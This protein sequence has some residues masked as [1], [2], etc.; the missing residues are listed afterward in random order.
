[1]S[2]LSYRLLDQQ[3]N[4]V[5]FNAGGS[6]STIEVPPEAH[7]VKSISLGKQ[8]VSLNY[9]LNR[10]GKY[11]VG[12]AYLSTGEDG[13]PP[14]CVAHYE[15]DEQ[16]RLCQALRETNTPLRVSSLSNVR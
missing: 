8:K 10:A 12:G 5:T 11:V 1:M 13:N 6:L 4:E 14:V 7:W 15:Y 2:D 9:T 3:N 16:G